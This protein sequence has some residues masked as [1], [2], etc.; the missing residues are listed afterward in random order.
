MS[1]VRKWAADAPVV[2]ACM[3]AFLCVSATLSLAERIALQNTSDIGTS[4]YSE[5]ETSFRHR[6]MG[7]RWVGLDPSGDGHDIALAK[8]NGVEFAVLTDRGADVVA[9]SFEDAR[10]AGLKPHLLEYNQ[11][12]STDNGPARA[13]SVKIMQIAVNGIVADNVDALVMSKGAVKGTM[14]GMNFLRQLKSYRVADGVLDQE[15]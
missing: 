14:L 3:L 9:F 5:N 2:S 1:D 7:S 10:R 8:I 4:R 15:N 11:R 13:A 6:M 12:I